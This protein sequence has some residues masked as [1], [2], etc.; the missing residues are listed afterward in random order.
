MGCAGKQ[1]MSRWAEIVVGSPVRV[2]PF[3][4]FIFLIFFSI[5]KFLI[6]YLNL[7]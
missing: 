1:E 5:S 6:P 4:F 3:L 2:F 7:F